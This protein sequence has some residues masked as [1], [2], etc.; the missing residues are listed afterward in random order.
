MKRFE[1]KVAL[2]TG[3]AAGIGR[4]TGIRLAQEG[5]ALHLVDVAA[6][7]LEET[8]KRCQELS[9]D[10][11]WGA[12]DVTDEARVEACFADVLAEHGRVDGCFANAG[13]GGR[14]TP[15]EEMSIEEWRRI[16][17]INQV[18]T[19][20]GMKR[21]APVMPEGGSIVNISSIGGM[22]GVPAFAYASTKWAVR[23][24]TKTAARELAPRG[25]RVNSIHP[26]FVHT[27]IGVPDESALEAIHAIVD[28]H[29]ERLTPMKRAGKPEELA[30]LAL[31]LASDESSYSTGSEFVAD[32]GLITGYPPPGLES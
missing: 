16:I 8:A 5:A 9:A 22:Q 12:C 26:G 2:V 29:A 1:G 21:V 30:R 27:H 17:E 28:A 14:G 23:G 18:G 6:E 24:M 32:G 3:A 10:V 20:L 25:I 4:A 31:F 19:Y 15:F 11:A 13:A 7:G